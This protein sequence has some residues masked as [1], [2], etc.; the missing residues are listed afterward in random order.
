[1]TIE[2][3]TKYPGGYCSAWAIHPSG[4]VFNFLCSPDGSRVR[5]IRRRL[6]S[7]KWYTLPAKQSVKW[8]P[9]IEQAIAR[10]MADG[11]S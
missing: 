6:E 9:L 1:M 8:A 4:R 2:F 11:V 10:K 7:G 3:L 5:A